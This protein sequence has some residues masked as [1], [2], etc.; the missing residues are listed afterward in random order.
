MGHVL[1]PLLV[2][3]MAALL[4]PMSAAYRYHWERSSLAAARPP[5]P[6]G[7]SRRLPRL[8]EP[9]EKLRNRPLQTPNPTDPYMAR[10][11]FRPQVLSACRADCVSKGGQCE[12][13]F[14]EERKFLGYCMVGEWPMVVFC[15]YCISKRSRR[16]WNSPRCL[17]TEGISSVNKPGPGF[18]ALYS[19]T[20]LCKCWQRQRKPRRKAFDWLK[21]AESHGPSSGGDSEYLD[22]LMQLGDDDGER[23]TRW[24]GGG[25]GGRRTPL[26]MPLLYVALPPPPAIIPPYD[27]L[28]D[29]QAFSDTKS[30]VPTPGSFG[31]SPHSYE[32]SSFFMPS[33]FN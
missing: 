22:N 28:P 9:G 23:S 24:G 33:F 16:C 29:V 18:V 17:R 1:L 13:K 31:Q 27:P 30:R 6:P 3:L 5:P 19:T 26:K 8:P 21:T 12:L 7:E 2:G 15:G 20:R 25:V 4:L 11:I 14:T 32:R 10:K